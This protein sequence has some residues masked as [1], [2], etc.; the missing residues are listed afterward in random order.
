MRKV[1]TG[2]LVAAVFGLGA[3]DLAAQGSPSL[4]GNASVTVPQV[5]VVVSVTDLSITLA[6]SDFYSGDSG[7]A[8]GQVSITTRA[9]VAHD[10]E[11]TATDITDGS[12]N[13]T[14][15]VQDSGDTFQTA[16]AT[17]VTVLSGLSRG[18]QAG[19]AIDFRATADVTTNDPG[20]YS[21][22]I[23]YTVVAN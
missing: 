5:L 22:T 18:T 11:V 20:A 9:N 2:L 6:N 16:G 12:T 19:N 3:A 4:Q 1:L 17:A 14:L 8:T 10:V 21:G 13:V 15:E 7:S 23:T